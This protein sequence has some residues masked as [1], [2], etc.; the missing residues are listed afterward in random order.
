MTKLCAQGEAP[1]R[2]TAV[3]INVLRALARAVEEAG[4]PRASLL[5]AAQLE[6]A[7]LEVVDA[8]LPRGTIYRLCELAV[9]LTGDPALGLHWGERLDSSSFPP[10][11]QLIAHTATLRDA[12]D[13]LSRFRPLL[14]E[15][16]GYQLQERGGKVTV[17]CLSLAGEGIATQRLVSE[18]IVTGVLRLV[19]SFAPRAPLECASFAYAA[20]SYRSEYARIFEGFEAFE[21]PFTGLV[22]DAA[23]MA[24][25]TSHADDDLHAALHSVVQRRVLRLTQKTPYTLRVRDLLLAR[26]AP[27]QHPMDEVARALGLSV[28]S[29]RRRLAAEGTPYST[30]ANEACATVSKR[31][32]LEPHCTI[33]EVAFAMG[34]SDTSAFHRA[35]KRWTGMTPSAFRC[36]TQPRSPMRGRGKSSD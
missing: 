11:S 27:Q 10:I 9:A 16:L 1:S 23:L 2:E 26:S 21:Q 8:H 4:V 31:L 13:A 34:F 19:R 18:M 14:S 29:L 30:I 6:P 24:A 25:R 33:Q 36:E 28:R 15:Q 7:Q 35:F 5:R 22:F 12:F 32:L 3:S 20:P 17:R